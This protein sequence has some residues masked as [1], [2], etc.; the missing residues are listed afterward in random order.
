[1]NYLHRAVAAG[2]RDHAWLEKDPDLEI[3]RSHEG[4]RTLLQ[5][6]RFPQRPFA[7]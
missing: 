6:A 1:M 4:F 2:Y 3:V 5:D 7:D